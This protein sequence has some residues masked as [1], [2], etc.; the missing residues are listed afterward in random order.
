MSIESK[1]A[2]R[3]I[4]IDIFRGICILAV[5]LLHLNIHFAFTKTFLKDALPKKLFT[6]LFWNGYNGVVVFFT[7]SG[8][9][10]TSSIIKKWG[11]LSQLSLKGFYWL[12]FS[13]IM[14]LLVFLLLVLSVLHLVGIEGFVIDVSKT[15]LPRAI[16]AVL[17]FHL[18]WLEIQVGYLPAN[19][20]VL[21]SIS[22]E[23]SFYFVFPLV[24]LFLK[25]EW[26]FVGVLILLLIVSPWAR[27]ALYPDSELGSKNHF[28]FLDAIAL[29]CMT[30][31]VAYRVV[32]PKLWNTYFLCMGWSLIIL[33]FVFKSFVYKSGLV[34]LGL[35]MTLQSIGVSLVLLWM[36]A[37]HR[38]GKQRNRNF[39]KWLR[40]MGIY[41]YE[42]Y[43]THMFVII[44]GAQ[45]F[46]HLNLGEHWLVP[47][48][49]LLIALSYW[50]GKVTFTFF[51]EPVNQRLRKS[52]NRLKHEK[53]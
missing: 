25:K 50:I 34:G 12:R 27:T 28:A 11:G 52:F 23:E 32:I 20:D 14:P 39:L 49:V 30:A 47:Y 18:N 46:K 48:S 41:S 4:G 24:C 16:F 42:I 44:F 40:H 37:S 6:L 38:S 29:G 26:Q 53:K 7:I 2:K 17:T 10:I 51:S 31:I 45:L 21:W 1:I 22:I 13:R 9:L 33:T 43:L 19:W 5:I 8:F 36:F 35:D 15:S 3:N